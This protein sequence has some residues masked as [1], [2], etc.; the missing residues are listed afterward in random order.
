MG[1]MKRSCFVVSYSIGCGVGEEGAKASVWRVS[2]KFRLD[3]G[4]LDHEENRRGAVGCLYT[5]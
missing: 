3:A 1:Q 4:S 2:W 5:V